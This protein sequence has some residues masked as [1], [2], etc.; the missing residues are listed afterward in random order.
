M[1]QVGS[2]FE[3]RSERVLLIALAQQAD[4]AWET[5]EHLAELGRLAWTAGGEVV[6]GITFKRDKPHPGCFVGT[7]QA[8]QIAE[9]V[10]EDGIDTVIFDDELTPAQGRNIE[11]I[12]GVKVLDRTQL[13]LDIFARHA[14]SHA[15]RLQ[16]ELAQMQYTLPRLRRMWTHL[17]RQRGGIGL[18]GGPG[19]QQIEVDR[20][21]IE[22]RITRLRRELETVRKR[23]AEQRKG[24]QRHGW[25]LVSLVGYTNAGKS[26]LLN[27]LTEAGVLADDKLFATLDPT[28]RRVK[29]PNN[30]DLLVTDT[31]GFIRKLPH[32][33]VESFRAT[34]EEVV[35]SDLLLHVVDAAHPEAESQVAA[36]EA[37]LREIGAEDKPLLMVLN[38]CDCAGTERNIAALRRRYGNCVEIS[39]RS[40][41]G[42]ETLLHALADALKHRNTELHLRIPLSEGSLLASLTASANILESEYQGQYALLRARVPAR[43]LGECQPFVEDTAVAQQ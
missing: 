38:K 12:V 35:E 23:R 17:E 4:K 40:G 11:Q 24:R 34:L 33:L 6:D 32:G 31:V 13:I 42:I 5:A 3:E 41:A 37:V 14:A 25:G 20:R 8:R 1:E 16:I 19:E 29:L 27:C 43:L 39:A 2:D 28:T 9:R 30:Q 15:G 7:G 21:R 22:E 26:T 10:A 18:R 36:V